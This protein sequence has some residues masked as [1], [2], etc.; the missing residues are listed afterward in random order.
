MK[1]RING[2]YA[3]TP[4]AADTAQLLV[5][6]GAALAGGARV[7]QY[8]NKTASPVLRRTQAKAL[9]ALCRAFAAPLI[10]NDHLELALEIEADGLHIGAEDGGIAQTRQALGAG[11]ILGVSCYN[12][13]ALAEAA[14]QAGADY[15]AFG[16]VFDSSTKPAAAHAPLT[17][18]QEA[19]TLAVLAGVPLVDIV[20][21]GGITLRNLPQL[22]Q[23][24]A[25]AA[26]VITDLFQAEDIEQR[27]RQLSLC[28]LSP[29]R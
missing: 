27:A 13:L 7:V 18:F 14:I 19:R 23:A 26:A 25:N 4:D 12:Q 22:V 8:R 6:V 10:I 15:V 9:L 21:I 24:G 11:R 2:L 3:V 20:G 29:Y 17:L 28:F 1:T 5:Q 16:S